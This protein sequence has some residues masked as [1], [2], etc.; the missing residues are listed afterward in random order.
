MQTSKYS[1]II[2]L[3]VGLLICIAA[4]NSFAQLGFRVNYHYINPSGD[5]GHTIQEAHGVNL[6][7]LYHLKNTPLTLGIDLGIGRYGAHRDFSAPIVFN[8]RTINN[9]NLEVRSNLLS[10]FFTAKVDLYPQGIIQ[11]YLNAKVGWQVFFSRFFIDGLS[12]S[13]R[14]ILSD[15]AFTGGLGGGIKISLSKIFDWQLDAFKNVFLNLEA[16]YL[17]GS[18]VTYLS[19]SPPSDQVQPV[20]NNGFGNVYK[21][22]NQLT[23][24]KVGVG[25]G[26]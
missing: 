16:N 7:G 12:R 24:I 1:L 10:G 18:Q 26:F 4:Q 17:L 20:R 9:Q 21:I 6:E 3:I 11:P 8:N 14:E 19:I 5:M 15:H 23:E 2:F 25:F 13:E 22:R